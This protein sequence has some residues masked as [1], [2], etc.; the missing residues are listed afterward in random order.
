MKIVVTGARGLIGWHASARLHA[1]NCAARFKGV[2]EPVELVMLGHADFDDTELLVDALRNAK[3]V[4]HFAGVNRAE[5]DDI[6]E[7]ANPEIAQALIRGCE[8]A[9][10]NP[11]I[12]YAN[13][14]HA[15]SDTPYGRSKRI[16]GEL[17]AS[18]VSKYTNLV[19][20]HIFGE[21]ARPF[22]NNVTATLIHQI[23]AGEEVSANPDGKV[24][25]LY[26]GAAAQAAIDA[27]M[28]NVIGD[29]V[30]EPRF[31]TVPD[32]LE[33]LEAFHASYE[34]NIYPDVSDDFDLAL[35]NTYRV[36]SY[37]DKWPRPLTLHTDARGTLFEAVKGG[38]GG[39]TFMSTTE[40]G[41]TRGDHYHLHKVERFLVVQGEAIIRIRKVLS[42]EVWEYP[43]NGDKPTPV[44]MPTLHTHSIENVGDGPLLTLFW[45]HDLFDPANPD[46]Y[47][48]KVIK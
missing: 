39:Q 13:S 26:A 35:F 34:A 41:V 38:G 44:D 17:I 18:R 10:S 40:S 5:S 29:V 25:L 24:Q 14:T 16:A 32:L 37:P 46:T 22:Y 6:V 11:H 30:P 47:A 48:D 43:V 1:L 23:F 3:A 4:L 33:K 7:K 9:G 15:D 20:P 19:L 45:T 42:D 2:P 31:F 12:V 36:A 28:N 27:V 21:C 8:I